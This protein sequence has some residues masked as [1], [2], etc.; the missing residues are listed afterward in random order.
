MGARGRPRRRGRSR[1][2]PNGRRPDHK[3]YRERPTEV[4]ELTELSPFSVFCAL[5]LG[6]TETD[7]Y[8][9]RDL[10]AVAA[11]FGVTSDELREFLVRHSLRAQDLRTASFDLESAQL[12]IQVAPHGISRTELA[13]TLF[14]E[15]KS[16]LPPPASD[17]VNLPQGD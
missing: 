15:L 17:E 2:N 7:E 1:P 10:N 11:R 6:I 14:A 13:R 16:S 8:A 3:G 4:P 9:A 12:D 5:Y